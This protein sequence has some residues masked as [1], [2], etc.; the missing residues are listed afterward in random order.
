M[1][2]A[3]GG[4]PQGALVE[5]VARVDGEEIYRG[6]YTVDDNG[7]CIIKFVLPNTISTGEGTLN[8]TITDGGEWIS[9]SNCI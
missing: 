5:A 1:K 7:L 6:N 2:R 4:V 9:R 8:C 3:E